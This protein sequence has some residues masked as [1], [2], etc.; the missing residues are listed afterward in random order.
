M[1]LYAAK[2]IVC[3]IVQGVSFRSFTKRNADTM[4]LCGY[5]KNRDDGKVEAI[6]EGDKDEIEALIEAMRSG[7]EKAQV[8][9]V[10][11]EWHPH[12]GIYHDF[13]VIY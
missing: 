4:G 9:N 10:E 6:I 1:A 7:P 12:S 13:K 5:V 8:K 3:G 11:I 2:V